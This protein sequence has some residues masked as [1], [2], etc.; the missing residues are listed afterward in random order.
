VGDAPQA[1][2]RVRKTVT[3]LFADVTGFTSLSERLDPESL[4]QVMTRYFDVMRGVVERHGGMVEKFMGDGVMAVF[5]VP[6]VH[7]D[8]PV[9]AARAAL[10]M[11]SAL[12]GVNDELV[13]AWDVHLRIHTGLNT[14]EVV[15]AESAVGQMF[16]LGDAVNVA[17]RLE[18]SAAPSE[19]L[20]GATTARLL[21]DVARLEPIPPLRVKGKAAPLRASQLTGMG[22][23]ARRGQP[24]PTVLFGRE[25]ELGA[26][27]SVFERVATARRP[28]T[29]TVV[30]E[31]GVGKSR[32]AQALAE[33]I[34]DRADVLLGRCLPYG[35]SITYWPVVEIVRRLTGL[36]DQDAIAALAGG[37]D[38]ARSIGSRIARVIGVEPGTVGVEEV[39]WAVRRL[40]EIR[41]AQHPIIVV[42]DDIHWAEPTLLDLLE[43][44]WSYASDVPLLGLF[45]ARPELTERPRPWGD[46][47]G[48]GTVLALDPLATEDAA[49]LLDRLSA[50]GAAE[51]E[52]A[53]REEILSTAEGNPFFLEQLVAMRAEPAG[54][55]ATTP[56]TVQALLDAR[57]DAL[58][59]GER[60]AIG[61]A[62]VEGR[63]FHAGAVAA[64][65]DDAVDVSACIDG[66]VRR[67]LVRAGGGQLPGESGYRFA[68]VLIRDVAYELL[69]KATRAELHSRY[70]SWLRG[71]AGTG[72]DEI[73]G[74][75]LERAYLCLAELRPRADAERRGLA[76]QAAG[77][78]GDAG[79]AA[80]ARGDLPG[81]VALLERAVDV[82]PA[83]V[84]LRR[85]LVPELGM[86]LVQL[87]RLPA[88]ERMLLDA[89]RD[90]NRRDDPIAEA[91]ALTARF[92]AQVQ[93]D[94]EAAGAELVG[95][96]DRLHDAF[97]GARDDLG[98]ARLWRAR[99][100]VY[101]LAG[102]STAAEADWV[103]AVRH[104]RRADDQH[105]TADAL[106]W[107]AS[108]AREGPYP[109]EQALGRCNAILD[110]LHADRRSQALVLRPMASLE[111]MAGR[112]DAAREL[113]ARG[114]ALLADL[115]MSMHGV[116]SDDVA[117]VAF[118]AGDAAAAEQA[119]RTSYAHLETMGERALLATTA[120][121]LARALH[122]QGRDDEALTFLDASQANAAAD[123]LAAQIQCRSVRAQVVARH[124]QVETARRLSSGA[125]ALARRTDWLTD[126]ADA[127]L[128]HAEVLTA[129]ARPQE[130]LAA[131]REALAV[132][133]RKGHRVG[134]DRARQAL[135]RT[136]PA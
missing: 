37:G 84:P 54:A 5:G 50:L 11:R 129:A 7:E 68:H 92:F 97:D 67:D 88:A 82:L 118:M 63:T 122:L 47:T 124:G 55:T 135:T 8:D 99:A 126:Q 38:E 73:V 106:V 43:N 26:L 136:V 80:L 100:L 103:R 15:V 12:Q 41:A 105:S 79:G 17:K 57:I 33:A 81:G 16:T 90:A 128:G 30:G 112:F 49:A 96:F 3:V 125:V 116:I 74:H 70:A 123:D 75:H 18:E 83:D 62:A 23:D 121:L 36:P 51:L 111:A 117:F 4:E 42:I 59:A 85:R 66:L 39:H 53:D 131:A 21:R 110:Q 89:A 28:E 34:G 134:V 31:A 113:I 29:V 13:H 77:H 10:E 2:S 60:A 101:W 25:R 127:L 114:A 119:L 56:A 14:G 107:L 22:R 24:V 64:L 48:A 133:E 91:H 1:P 35:E 130:A 104:A 108:A 72:Y 61:A 40:L 93:I 102:R 46:P 76:L 6:V 115:G 94:S 109:V 58:P 45:L 71:R 86:A 65:V 9:R 132:Y 19:I 87:G 98:L 20:V 44:V 32:L 95:R 27:A 78:L 120:C 69:P 52:D